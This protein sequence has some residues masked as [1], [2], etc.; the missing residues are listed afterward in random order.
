[1]AGVL[2]H[3]DNF[4]D[5]LEE[6]LR[7]LEAGGPE[8]RVASLIGTTLITLGQPSR[9]LGWLELAKRW[10]TLPGDYD[11]LIGDCWALL[12]DDQRA[13][14]AYRRSIDLRPEITEGWVGLCR[15]RL[16]QGDIKTAREIWHENQSRITQ[17]ADLNNNAP[18]MLAQIEF[19]ARNYLES[20]R[21]YREL[22]D[23]DPTGGKG[24]YG[25]ITYTSALGR[26]SQLTGDPSRGQTT[27]LESHRKELTAHPNSLNPDA[28]YRIAAIKA[29][30]DEK[31]SAFE[32][33]PNSSERG[34][35]RLS[36][37]PPRPAI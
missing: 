11:A 28:H 25:G 36:I 17:K 37:P 32:Y 7:A 5:A 20:E 6:Q 31:E 1:M 26:L 30:L 2:I 14:N 12:C 21:L 19:F 13:E 15:L 10:A 9:A 3:Q 27:L 16:L 22:A 33:L 4:A 18:K 24:F 35:D 8:E 29:S 34:M 23:Q